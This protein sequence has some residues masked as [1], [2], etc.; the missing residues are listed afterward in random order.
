MKGAQSNRS[1]DRQIVA[2]QAVH[3]FFTR[4]L[5]RHREGLALE[6]RG[7][8]HV[9]QV[10][11]RGGLGAAGVQDVLALGHGVGHHLVGPVVV[12]LELA[13]LDDGGAGGSIRLCCVG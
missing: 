12:D 9:G 7:E 2:P 3:S 11:L 10:R 1:V 8:G 4:L 5:R 6:A 13:R